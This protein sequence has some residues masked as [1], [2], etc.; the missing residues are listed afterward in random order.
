MKR[1]LVIQAV[2]FVVVT[3]GIS[4]A[5]FGL[6]RLTGDPAIAFVPVD[7]TNEE[8]L[9]VR[10][11]MGLDEPIMVQY[12]I[13]VSRAAQ[14]DFGRAFFHGRRPAM[15]L[16]VERIPATAL[17]GVL[18]LLV[19]VIVSVPLGILAA[20]KR[21]S[22]ID[23]A[24]TSFVAVGQAMPGFW[25]GIIL[26][27]IFAVQLRWVPPSGAGEWQNLV[28]PVIV[29]GVLLTPRK[30]RLVRSRMVEVLA[31]DYIR[32]ARAKGLAERIVLYGHA[33]R[34]VAITFVAILGLQ[35]A[36]LLEGTVAVE[37]V[38][39][40]PGLGSLLVG[41]IASS[42][43][44]VVQAAVILIALMTVAVNMLT[45]LTVK[46]IDPRIRLG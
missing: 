1:Y 31:S 15:E 25:F 13:W 6:I 41:S 24:C 8:Y 39:A 40:W 33:F 27:I 22:W 9:A 42:D 46:F 43:L 10:Q 14:G 17:L 2:Q 12:A 28:L 30:M 34:N 11:R 16:V 4:V 23:Q 35:F 21:N 18:G 20:V 19:S 38:F 29:L 45:D 37:A 36:S 3:I 7:A 32:T 44:P 5:V 26:I